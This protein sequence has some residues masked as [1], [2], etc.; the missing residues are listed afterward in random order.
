MSAPAKSPD[1]SLSPLWRNLMLLLG[2][3]LVVA[4]LLWGVS[5]IGDHNRIPGLLAL[6]AKDSGVMYCT[7]GK[8]VHG[9]GSLLARAL[10]PGVFRC[11]EWKLRGEGSETVRGAT[12]LPDSPR[13]LG[14]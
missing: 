6:E 4:G 11:T 13:R 3:P 10:E 8:I 1:D 12:P 9:D 5:V 7:A 14:M 2:A